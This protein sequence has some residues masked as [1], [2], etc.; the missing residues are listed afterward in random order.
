VPITP[1]ELDMAEKPSTD[2]ILE[3]VSH[4]SRI[5]LAEVKAHPKGAVFDEPAV[6]VMPGDPDCALRLDVANPDMVADLQALS[7][8]GVGQ[9][10]EIVQPVDDLPLRLI[11][12]RTMGA[13]N[14]CHLRPEI[15]AAHGPNPV[16]MHPDDLAE[17][18]I[19][20][21]Q[22]VTVASSTGSVDGIAEPDAALRRG[23]VSMSAGFGGSSDQDGD[24]RTVGSNVNR[25]LRVDHGYDRYSGQ[26][27]MGN[28]PVRVSAR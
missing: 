2:E 22:E 18:G 4:G 9:S 13:Q 10:L 7:R 1:H 20:D 14:S 17:L 19:A 15:P 23:L 24:V 3:I 25:L 16:Y 8:G 28:V 11:P 26:P 5:P 27:L 6:Y 21:G 12:R